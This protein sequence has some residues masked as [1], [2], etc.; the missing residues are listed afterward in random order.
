MSEYEVLNLLHEMTLLMN[1][2]KNNENV[3]HQTSHL[4]VT[5]F[6]GQRKNWWGS[7]FKQQ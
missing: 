3:D 7:L 6:I 2:S 4:I 5:D 1:I